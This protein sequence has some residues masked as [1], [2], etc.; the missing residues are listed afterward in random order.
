MGRG[1]SSWLGLHCK[2]ILES[3]QGGMRRMGLA[4]QPEQRKGSLAEQRVTKR[5]ELRVELSDEQDQPREGPGEV[6]SR[7]RDQLELVGGM[8]RWV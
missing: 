7:R 3:R 6:C 8:S 2:L 4:T 1:M 5:E